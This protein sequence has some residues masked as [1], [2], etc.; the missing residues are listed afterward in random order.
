MDTIKELYWLRFDK[1]EKEIKNDL[2]KT[3]CANFLQKFINSDYTVLDLGAG[4]CEFINSINCKK[5]F[6][7]DINEDISSFAKED[8]VTFV[9]NSKNMSEIRDESIDVVFTSEFFE[10]LKSTDELFATL[11]EI[12]RILKKDGKL[13]VLCPNIR[14]L[15]DRYWDFI[16]HRLPLS[17]AGLKEALLLYHFKIIKLIPKFLPYTTKSA[18]PKSCFLLKLYLKIPFLWNIFGRQ[19]FIVAQK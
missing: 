12:F 4:Y 18:L 14:Y 11:V 5:K 19:M 16:D 6:A 7:V 13:V 8:V 15:A 3:L 10:H 17:D 9:A 1:S 2:W